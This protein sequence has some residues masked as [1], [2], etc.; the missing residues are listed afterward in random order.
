[1][2]FVLILHAHLPYVLGHG[3][4]P[5]GSDW[6]VEAVVDCY[7]PLV[8]VLRRL[9]AAGTP[10]PVTISV[11]PVL[12]AQLA[13]PGLAG[14]VEDFLAQRLESCD[15][16]ERAYHAA[17]DST[18]TGV[19]RWWRDRYVALRDEFRALDGGLIGA[20][21]A[22]ERDGRIEVMSSAATHA[23]L[24]LLARDESIAL[25]LRAGADEHMRH[26][27]RPAPG[28]WLP[29]CGY[30]PAGPWNPIAGA[31]ARW[32]RDG[33]ERHLTAVGCRYVVL[34]AHSV[35]A[36]ERAAA[37]D[38]F[39]R[40]GARAAGTVGG[41]G[42][43][44]APWMIDGGSSAAARSPYRDYAIGT[45]P[46]GERAPGGTPGRAPGAAPGRALGGALV[47]A[48]VRDPE[49]TRQVWSRDGGYPGGAAYRE[50]HKLTFPGGLRLWSVTDPRASLGEK[51][52]YDPDAAV[53]MAREH[54]SHFADLLHGIAANGTPG[55]ARVVVAPFDAELFGHWWFEGPEWLAALYAE[56][57]RAANGARATGDRATGAQANGARVRPVTALEH[58]HATR[59][60]AEPIVP[61]A[62]TWGQGGDF[63]FWLNDDTAWTWRRLWQ[64]EDRF[65]AVARAAL[66]NSA[67]RPVLA[68][69]AREL[70]LAQASDWQFMYSAG[71]VP[72]YA[73]R[74][75][76]LHADAAGDL[77][78][79][80]ERGSEPGG[81][82]GGG[83]GGAL[84]QAERLE[85][86]DGIFPLVLRA[87]EAAL[88]DARDGARHGV[89]NGARDGERNNAQSGVPSGGP[90]GTRVGAGVAAP[91]A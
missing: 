67:A 78:T 21:R 23:L 18:L 69:A 61:A 87:V 4:W 38:A 8:G 39:G 88:D 3:R 62:G 31:P 66:A 85:A 28:L 59:D 42:A 77:V 1:V 57:A 58:V 74:R 22:L 15:A 17:G 33:L 14:E 20:L 44:G 60:D 70:L 72:D 32:A 82:L 49:T 53:A 68:Q 64:L 2:N 6:L 79:A 52:H 73:A 71:A 11:T 29:E 30:R 34:D 35:A 25:Q 40:P 51:L 48:L 81:T 56:L 13:A 76:T 10:A 43:M 54:A 12:A 63:G 47:R 65:W 45:G 24:P 46:R 5:H 27:G 37:Y 41:G 84:R 9:P 16:S 83:L 90:H 91:A 50:F 86:R 80:L 7:L 89:Q 75:F 19:V 26:F 55:G 36:G